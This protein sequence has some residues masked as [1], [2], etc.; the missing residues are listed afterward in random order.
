MMTHEKS[1]ALVCLMG[2][3]LLFGAGCSQKNLKF[4]GS[5]GFVGEES[6]NGA[7]QTSSAGQSDQAQGQISGQQPQQPWPSGAQAANQHNQFG[8]QDTGGRQGNPSDPSAFF[9]PGTESDAQAG[10]YG[11]ASDSNAW[12][13]GP[14][15]SLQDFGNPQSGFTYD[16]WSNQNGVPEER[17]TEQFANSQF[18]YSGQDS[19][20][21]GSTYQPS[22][23]AHI[24]GSQRENQLHGLQRGMF[25]DGITRVELQD[26]FFEYDSWRITQ[27]GTQALAH[28]ADWLLENGNRTLVVE[29]HCDQ[30]GTQNYNLVLGRKRAEAVKAYLI[31][32]GVNAEQVQ[33]ISYGEER[34]FCLGSSERCYQLNRRGHLALNKE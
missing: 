17:L 20:G 10:P 28:D 5:E 22:G 13:N 27:D 11:Q 25:Q 23:G 18:G 26:V 34:P 14:L 4:A 9:A 19:E 21:R 12:R 2:T 7:G 29:G 31:D 8:Q 15:A 24:P 30:R 3:A 32:L 16:P 1:M 6:L 33:M